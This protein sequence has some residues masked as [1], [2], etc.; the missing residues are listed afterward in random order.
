MSYP[1]GL[2]DAMSKQLEDENR[3]RRREKSKAK[4]KR[5]RR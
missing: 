4:A 3:Q 2:L 1:V 5:G